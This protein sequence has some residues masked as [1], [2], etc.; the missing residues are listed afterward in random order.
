MVRVVTLSHKCTTFIK[1]SYCG[2]MFKTNNIFIFSLNPPPPKKKK[3]K[4]KNK[5]ENNKE[6]KK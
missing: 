3:K 1:N 6:K 4:K 2:I 5:R